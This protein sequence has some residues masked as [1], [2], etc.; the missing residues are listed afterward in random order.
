MGI[1]QYQK[2]GFAGGLMSANFPHIKVTLFEAEFHIDKSRDIQRSLRIPA[3]IGFD[4]NSIFLLTSFMAAVKRYF[5]FAFPT[6][7]NVRRSQD[8]RRASSRPFSLDQLERFIAHVFHDKRVRDLFS[9]HD[10]SEIMQS[11]REVRQWAAR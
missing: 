9:L 10:C 7:G 3:V 6:R 4:Q 5:N 11:F 8:G 1:L 2:H